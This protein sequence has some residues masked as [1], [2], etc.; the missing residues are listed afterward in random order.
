M[1]AVANFSHLYC[2]NKHY[3]LRLTLYQK[4]LWISLKTDSLDLAVNVRSPIKPLLYNVL[5]FTELKRYAARCGISSVD[6]ITRLCK[7]S[8]I[9][10]FLCCPPYI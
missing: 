4:Q 6:S 3:Y 9:V 7:T 10:R 5:V 2:R 8:Q 1:L